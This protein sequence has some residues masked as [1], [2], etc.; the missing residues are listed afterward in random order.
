MVSP[1]N[2]AWP[3]NVETVRLKRVKSNGCRSDL[4]QAGR[5]IETYSAYHRVCMDTSSNPNMLLLTVL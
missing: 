5:A 1:P 4:D 3:A 2:P